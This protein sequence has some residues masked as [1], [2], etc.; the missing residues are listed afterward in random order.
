MSAFC[1][2]LCFA[3]GPNCFGIWV[4]ELEC[5]HATRTQSTAILIALEAKI[6]HLAKSCQ[7]TEMLKNKQKI[8]RA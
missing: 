4:E 5:K 2:Y 6:S 8:R 3:Q 1:F 7:V